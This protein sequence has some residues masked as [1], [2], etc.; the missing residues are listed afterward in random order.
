MLDLDK[1]R[2][3]WTDEQ[4]IEA[5][6][7]TAKKLPWPLRLGNLRREGWTGRLPVYLIWC[8]RCRLTPGHGFTVAH[9]AGVQGRL[10]CAYC[11]ARCDQRLPS[12]RVKGALLN[13]FSSPR[14]LMLLIIL[15]ILVA[16]AASSK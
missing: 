4:F 10:A 8:R 16:S 13:P 14:L 2:D 5:Y 12:R 6:G 15:A 1:P 9:P 11:G 3:L 7:E